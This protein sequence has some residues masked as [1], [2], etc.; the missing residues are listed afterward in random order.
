MGTLFTHKKSNQA[1]FY[2]YKLHLFLTIS[3]LASGQI[4]PQF[5]LPQEKADIVQTL[6]EE[7][8]YLGTKLTPAIHPCFQAVYYDIQLVLEVTLIPRGISVVLGVPINSKCSTFNLYHATPLYQPNCDN[9]TASLFQLAKPFLAVA[10]DDSRYAELD[11]S[12]LQ[13][14]SSN[15]RI[16]LCREGFSTTADDTLLCL[17]FLMF[18]YAILALRNCPATSVLLPDAS[19]AF[20][21]AERLYHVISLESLLHMKNASDI[22]GVSVLMILCQ[23]CTLRPRCHST[24]TLNQ[25][26]LVLE[27][28]ME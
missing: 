17:S 5:L 8:N 14:C 24:L 20:Y 16:R 13:Q 26:D 2:A 22:H 28:D 7:E 1:A 23:V 6:S 15:N 10:N 11:I 9:K 21:L 12:T 19:R 18:D 27:P 3:S 25:G 4:T